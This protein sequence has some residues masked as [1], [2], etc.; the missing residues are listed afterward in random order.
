MTHPQVFS[1]GKILAQENISAAFLD[2]N[3]INVFETMLAQNGK[4]FLLDDHLKRLFESAKTTGVRAPSEFE[5]K[6]E[7]EEVVS[8]I[9]KERSCIRV[10]LF[11]EQVVTFVFKRAHQTDIYKKGVVLKTSAVKR[12]SSESMRPEAKTGQFL[13]GILADLDPQARDSFETLFLDREGYIKEARIWNIFIV[14]KGSLKTPIPSG[15]LDG[16]TRRFVIKCTFQEQIGVLET[17]LT[18]HDVWN[19]EEAFL[20]NTSGGIVPILSLDGR[21]IGTKIP[22]MVTERLSRRFETELNRELK[23]SND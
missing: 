4:I 5:I 6:K 10:T 15:I 14:K 1:N 16:V 19:A 13:N 12:S 8:K 23:N 22:G 3:E 20:T 11:R 17:S 18:R 9:S 7:L 21:L 2:E